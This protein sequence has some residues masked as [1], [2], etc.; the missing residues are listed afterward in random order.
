MTAPE[1][2]P[3]GAIDVDQLMRDLKARVQARRAA[4]ELDPAVLHLPFD[5]DVPG[6]ADGAPAVHLRPETAY[7]SKPYVGRPITAAKRGLIRFLYHFLNDAVTQV[8]AAL[9]R[10]DGDLADERDGRRRLEGRVAALEEEVARLRDELREARA[11]RG[12][13]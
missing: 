4:G 2:G 7:S 1:A 8:N 13:G 5:A 6:D 10:L 3:P 11:A 9:A 12:S